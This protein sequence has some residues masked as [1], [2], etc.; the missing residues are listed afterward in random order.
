MDTSSNP[1]TETARQTI[2]DAVSERATLQQ[3]IRALLT[4]REA[5]SDAEAESLPNARSG[6]T[7]LL[8]EALAELKQ[9]NASNQAILLLL[10]EEA[11]RWKRAFGWLPSR[12]PRPLQGIPLPGSSS[13][14]PGSPPPV[15]VQGGAR[16]E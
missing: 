10:Q 16:D 1:G 9:L 3:A 4:T 7:Q 5:G 6:A 11:N 13:P 2:L 8:E 12:A 15:A 14:P